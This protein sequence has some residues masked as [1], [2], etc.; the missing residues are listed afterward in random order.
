MSLRFILGGSGS[1]KTHRCLFQIKEALSQSQNPI[2]YIVPEQYSLEAERELTSICSGGALTRVNV[3]S[4]QRLA[5]NIFSKCGGTGL[6]LL[7]DTGKIMLLRKILSQLAPELKYYGNSAGK[8][9]FMESL[10][11]MITEFYQY[12]ITEETLE[13]LLPRISKESLRIKM[14]DLMKIYKA[15]KN[16]AE[17]NYLSTDHSLKYFSDKLDEYDYLKDA[18]VWVDGFYGFTPQEYNVL[19]R[20]MTRVKS[21]TLC[22][23]VDYPKA[24]K[25][26]PLDPFFETKNTLAR[27]IKLAEQT[28]TTTEKPLFLKKCIRHKSSPEFLFLN[29]NFFNFKS[30]AYEEPATNIVITSVTEKYEEITQLAEE[31]SCLVLEKGYRYK[32]IAVISSAISNYET[33]I[34]TLFDLYEIPYFSDKRRDI[35][36]YPLTELILGAVEVFA[37]N[38]N[39]ESVF[40]FLKTGLTP[41]TQ[42]E[43]DILENYALAYGIKGY[44]WDTEF[45]YGFESGQFPQEQVNSAKDKL[46]ECLKSLGIKKHM[47][48]KDY[49]VSIFNMLEF[50]KVEDR[51]SAT[52]KNAKEYSQVW[53]KICGLFDKTVEILGEEKV[54]AVEFLKIL[55]AG[56]KSCDM[57]IIPASQDQVIIGDLERTRLPN[58]KALFV[59]GANDESLSHEASVITDEERRHLLSVGV[60]LAPDK[61]RKIIQEQ[62]LQYAA[63]TK[64]TDYLYLS[65][66]NLNAEGKAMRPSL[67]ISKLQKLFPERI[68]IKKQNQRPKPS[69]GKIGKV[70]RNYYA[71][72]P[73]DNED[74]VLLQYFS[75]SEKYQPKLRIIKNIVLENKE[76]TKLNQNTVKRLY[77]KT[78]HSSVSRL[79]RF[80]KCPFS[81]F[82]QYCLCAKK[83][84]VFEVNPMDIGSLFHEVLDKFSKLMENSKTSW[85]S[86][87]PDNIQPLIE[88]CMESLS[89]SLPTHILD[90]NAGYRYIL[91]RVKRI[92]AKSVWALSEHIKR[93]ELEPYASEVAFNDSSPLQAISINLNNKNILKIT[94]RIDR[95]DIIDSDGN[96]FIRI[97]DYK[98]GKKRFDLSDIYF[99]MQMQLL[100]YLD[101]LLENGA[102]FFGQEN[103]EG[104]ILPGGVFY[105]NI[106]D[107]IV[108]SDTELT[109]E[110]LSSAIL[111]GFKMSGLVLADPELVK[112]MDNEIDGHSNILPVYIKKDNAFGSV[113]QVASLENF[114]KLRNFV[115][116]KIREVGEK[117]T[118]GNISINPY[119]KGKETGCDYCIYKS[120]CGFEPTSKATYNHVKKIKSV[121]EIVQTIE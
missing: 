116:E 76:Q 75:L 73:I 100:L 4:F 118:D 62:L 7:D 70:L 50:M 84:P 34:K 69:F 67:L 66:P 88:E 24:D 36:S 43:T 12:C 15:Y 74:T 53:K 6:P 61:N 54:S 35:S 58:I 14:L 110:L 37:Y 3:L 52:H 63:L 22:L 16:F 109:G 72:E 26:R 21:L 19:Q 27:L 48:V 85:R 45:K 111:S 56:I 44:K 57:G 47:T 10:A 31:I 2:I 107:P 91:K 41:L 64:P 113:S 83:R 9:G 95:L 49:A 28:G 104:K 99:G 102:N 46:N 5:F 78:I 60:E 59:I 32:D 55:E 90:S 29:R 11:S 96:R 1:G 105:F 23:T 38:R 103:I 93:G 65:Y 30:T 98:S 117:I 42:E 108:E 80:V 89:E 39:Y 112:K 79:E 40:R 115:T 81:Y 92:A 94:G 18:L 82:V 33:P 8:Q 120:I 77:S 97:L 119:K 101:A 87:T 20:L 86:L 17:T 13:E 68:H 114:D 71:N 106:D 51:L 25:I 121:S